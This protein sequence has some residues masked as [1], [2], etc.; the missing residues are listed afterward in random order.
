MKVFII[1]VFA[2]GFVVFALG[3]VVLICLLLALPTMLLWNWLMPSIFGLCKIGFWKALGLSLL[4]S[5]LFR[6]N[7]TIKKD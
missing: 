3:F 6:S 7:T 5:I 2:L 1:F 4:C